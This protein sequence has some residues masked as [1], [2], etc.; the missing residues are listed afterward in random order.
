MSDLKNWKTECE[1]RN[2]K[3]FIELF[4]KEPQIEQ[5][6]ENYYDFRN[7]VADCLQSASE[8]LDDLEAFEE[9]YKN[10]NDLKESNDIMYQAF[11]AAYKVAC[12]KIDTDNSYFFDEKECMNLLMEMRSL[13]DKIVN[14]LKSIDLLAVSAGI[15]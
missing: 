13:H 7:E 10:A 4:G 15:N 12:G 5:L 3:L 6:K 2:C 1:I 9:N 8:D 11:E 14:M